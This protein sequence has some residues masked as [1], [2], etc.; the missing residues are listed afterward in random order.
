MVPDQYVQFFYARSHFRA[1]WNWHANFPTYFWII[2]KNRLLSHPTRSSDHHW[3]QWLAMRTYICEFFEE[4]IKEWIFGILSNYYFHNLCGHFMEDFTKKVRSIQS[5]AL[6]FFS[7]EFFHY[8]RPICHDQRRRDPV[9][10]RN[11]LLSAAFF[12]PPVPS[13][14]ITP[15]GT[16]T[17]DFPKWLSWEGC[18][19]KSVYDTRKDGVWRC[20]T[21]ISTVY[22]LS[23]RGWF[24][25]TKRVMRRQFSKQHHKLKRERLQG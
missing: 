11:A 6:G 13:G 7:V 10:A 21:R 19:G 22:Y 12:T 2:F 17:I 8:F 23:S 20:P 3:I 9:L 14:I 1:P 24:R 25:L 15:T 16:N 5:W 4:K 18:G